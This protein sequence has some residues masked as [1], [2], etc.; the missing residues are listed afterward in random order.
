MR[1][2]DRLYMMLDNLRQSSVNTALERWFVIAYGP[3][4]SGKGSLRAAPS[5]KKLLTDKYTDIDV[6]T[7]VADLYV[8]STDK[9]PMTNEKYLSLRGAADEKSDEMLINAV[10]KRNNIIWETTGRT[11]A[12]IKYVIEFMKNNG[13]FI[14]LVIPMLYLSTE[15][16]R[17]K[18]RGRKGD[19]CS[20]DRLSE[21]RQI[22]YD[23][24]EDISHVCDRTLIFNNNNKLFLVY[25]SDSAGPCGELSDI[26]SDPIQTKLHKF[27]VDTCTKKKNSQVKQ[28]SIA[29]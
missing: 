11:P 23:N 6:D 9:S 13:F 20:K 21:I 18:S 8:Q 10:I 24:F 12:W 4:G 15:V 2:E 7:I 22:S 3:P 29:R 5:I 17:C 16:E 26:V 28:K 25:D 27:V 14:L 19:D 1:L